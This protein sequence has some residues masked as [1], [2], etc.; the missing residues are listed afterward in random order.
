[1]FSLKRLRKSFRYAF[2][3]LGKIFK[4]EQ[5]L[6]FQF[7]AALAVLPLGAVFGI[8]KIEWA[9]LILS[10]TLVIAMEVVNSAVERISDVLKPR[11]NGYVKEIKDIMAAG[12]MIASLSAVI[13]GL[14]VFWPYLADF[15]F[16]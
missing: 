11:L 14:I 7:F 9:I 16:N 5:N 10:I 8:S 1:M 2:K 12:V 13:I 3:G 6:R 4:E 15:L